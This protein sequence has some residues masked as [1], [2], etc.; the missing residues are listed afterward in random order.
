L[1]RGA[2]VGLTVRHT[3]DHMTRAVLEG[4]AYGLR[5]SFEL[6]RKAGISQINQVRISGG[7][8]KSQLW[9]QI[10]ADV[11]QAEMVTVNTAE[12][13]AFGAA[14]LAATGTG[15]F[16]TVEEACQATIKITST[17]SPSS[18]SVAYQELYPLYGN[19]YPALKPAFHHMR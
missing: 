17:V 7:G 3:R 4:V 5:D 9:R 16:A 18:Q 10:L 19:L 1:A 2:F 12:G 14:L 13:A 15:A 6:M 11:F 8:A